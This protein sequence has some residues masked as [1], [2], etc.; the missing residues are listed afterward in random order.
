VSLGLCD[1]GA[2][3]V[4]SVFVQLDVLEDFVLTSGIISGSESGTVDKLIIVIRGLA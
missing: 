4:E 1:D 3:L 2:G